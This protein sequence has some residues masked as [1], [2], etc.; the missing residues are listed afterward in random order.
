MFLW[1]QVV[2]V[3]AER[4][5]H[6]GSC[7]CESNWWT[8]TLSVEVVTD[9]VP[10]NASGEPE[11]WAWK[12]L[13]LMF[14]WM[15]LVNL[16]AE[17][18]SRYWSCSCECKWWTWTL[19]VEV[20]MAHVPV[21]ATGEPESW[22]WKSL[23]IMFLWMQV[24]NVNAE[25]ASRYGSCS[26]ECKW[27]TWTLSV[28]VVIAHAASSTWLRGLG[29]AMRVL[30]SKSSQP[31]LVLMAL[32]WPSHQTAEIW[33]AN[34]P[35]WVFAYLYLFE[36]AQLRVHSTDESSSIRCPGHRLLSPLTVKR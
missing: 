6:Y 36:I 14:L 30:A 12:S 8:W 3:N 1:M 17:R 27:W 16:K 35:S 29:N 11:R 9:H 15:Q 34:L 26:C 32:K 31:V 33:Y 28:E 10:V 23:L 2:N 24:V 5:S 19:S 7:S 22:A 20:I 25:R 13:W 4:G 21:N 18:G